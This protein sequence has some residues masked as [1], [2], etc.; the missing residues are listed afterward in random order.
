MFKILKNISIYSL[1]NVL[2]KGVMFLLLPLYTRVLNPADYG[3]LELVYLAGSIL[4]ILYGLI[5][6]K[7]YSRIYFSNKDSYFRKTLF[8]TGQIFNLFCAILFACF[9]YLNSDYLADLFFKYPKGAYYLQ[10]IAFITIIEVLTHIPFNNLRIRQLP[11]IFVLINLLKLIITTTLTVYF[12]A[13][14]KIGVEGVLYAKLI[15]DIITLAVLYYETRAEYLFKFSYTQL[16][17]ML[18]FSVFLIP[19]SLSALILNM[20]NRFFLQEYQS[21]DDVGLYSLGAKLAGII[22]FL[23]TDPIKKAFGPH[24]Y[25]LIDNPVLCKKTLADFSKIFVGGLSIVALSIS[26]FS[27]ELILIMS[28]ASYAG[29][30]NIVFVLS[31]SYLFLGLGGNIV[32]GINVTK[33]TW[34]TAIIWFGSAIINILLNILLIPPFGR[35]GAA[36]AT[37]LSV[38]LITV[39]YFIAIHYIYPVKFHYFSMFKVFVLMILFN[40]LGT[41]VELDILFSILIKLVIL[42]FFI[43][44]LFLFKVFQFSELVSIRDKVF[45]K[46]NLKIP[47]RNL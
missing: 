1:G 31:I 11:K 22:P 41:L 43:A 39:S 10:L 8:G 23:F 17:E 32:F 4:S 45:L 6:E 30:H 19:S 5:V 24:L 44:S 29:S 20:S 27:R 38:V 33:K 9:I 7:G 26:L 15:G 25:S 37:M 12:V 13:F 18:Q 14:A 42:V 34:I 3:K 16:K 40:Y 46:T 2:N 28:D 47:K 35:I 36:Y 21:L